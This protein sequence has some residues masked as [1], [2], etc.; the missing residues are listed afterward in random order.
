M[1]KNPAHA[2]GLV[3]R[4]SVQQLNGWTEAVALAR[5]NT[6]DSKTIFHRPTTMMK[7]S[8]CEKFIHCPSK[9][10][11][12]FSMSVKVKTEKIGKL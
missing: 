6:V 10:Q 8:A 2:N 12:A 7:I 9:F 3:K 11:H 1:I 5:A 4:H